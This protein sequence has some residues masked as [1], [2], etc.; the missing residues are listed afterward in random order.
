MKKFLKKLWRFAVNNYFISIFLAA[1]AFVGVV[2]IYKLF[3]VQPTFVY[4]KV[5]VGQGLWWA[6]T[7]RPSFWFVEALKKGVMETD[8]TGEPI[9]EIKDVLY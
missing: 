8:L 2:S 1:I 7:Q 6:T 3:F 4:A 9:A 5:K